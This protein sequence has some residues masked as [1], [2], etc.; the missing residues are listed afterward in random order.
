[1]NIEELVTKLR[2]GQI[3]RH[4]SWGQTQFIRLAKSTGNLIDERGQIKSLHI[5]NFNNLEYWRCYVM[6]PK[7]ENKNTTI[8][9]SLQAFQALEQGK[10]I[11][12]LVWDKNAYLVKDGNAIINSKGNSSVFSCSS[13]DAEWE[14]YRPEVKLSELEYGQKYKINN[15]EYVKISPIEYFGGYMQAFRNKNAVAC[16]NDTVVYHASDLL[17]ERIA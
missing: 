1:M 2:D 10:K 16:H 6:N 13:L 7:E 17:V 3:L 5:S 11:R 8:M 15:I 4:D 12:A 9:N 14:E